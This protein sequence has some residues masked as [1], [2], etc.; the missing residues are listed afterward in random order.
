MRKPTHT[1]INVLAVAAAVGLFAGTQ[2]GLDDNRPRG[3]SI[4]GPV[5]P[6]LMARGS[7][8]YRNCDAARAAG[9]A[10]LRRDDAGYRR[11]LDRDGD[12][13]ACEPYR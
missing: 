3:A 9:A 5:R 11:P 2:W 1:E 13:V 12:G 6:E 10:P 8:Y 4:D 7:V